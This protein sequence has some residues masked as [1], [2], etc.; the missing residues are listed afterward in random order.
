MKRVAPSNSATTDPVA[1]FLELEKVRRKLEYLELQRID[2]KRDRGMAVHLGLLS[3]DKYWKGLR[4]IQE[5]RKLKR[6]QLEAIVQEKGKEH[7]TR[8]YYG[9]STPSPHDREEAATT[10][11]K[12]T[13]TVKLRYYEEMWNR[14]LPEVFWVNLAEFM[15]LKDKFIAGCVSLFFYKTFIKSDPLISRLKALCTYTPKQLEA[16]RLSTGADNQPDW[17]WVYEE[18]LSTYQNHSK[19][20]LVIDHVVRRQRALGDRVAFYNWGYQRIDIGDTCS[21]LLLRTVYSRDYYVLDWMLIQDPACLATFNVLPF[22]ASQKDDTDNLED[23]PLIR[24]L[25]KHHKTLLLQALTD[26]GTFESLRDPKMHFMGV[27]RTMKHEGKFKTETIRVLV[28]LKK[29]LNLLLTPEYGLIPP[30]SPIWGRIGKGVA[31]M[32]LLTEEDLNKAPS[33]QQLV[34]SGNKIWAGGE[35]P[36]ADSFW[37]MVY[38]KTGNL[39]WRNESAPIVDTALAKLPYNKHTIEILFKILE[40]FL[41]DIPPNTFE[42]GAIDDNVGGKQKRP[43]VA[44]NTKA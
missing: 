37:S 33:Y 22:I 8:A 13:N 20:F 16:L 21:D 32:G 28:R 6:Y 18:F 41:K 34:D 39:V 29:E 35:P 14:G 3:H 10:V 11:K 5:S 27:A 2:W 15:T 30:G 12:V 17:V 24:H 4:N 1:T 38:A 9:L 36:P 43:V 19:L 40:D 7:G 31:A 26:T 44:V 42:E 23:G 25:W